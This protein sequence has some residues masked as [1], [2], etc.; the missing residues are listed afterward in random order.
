[1]AWKKGQ[2]GNPKGRPARLVEKSYLEV[3]LASVSLADWKK[4]V[5][6]AKKEAQAGGADGARAREWLAK[7]LMPEHTIVERWLPGNEC[8]NRIEGELAFTDCERG[9]QPKNGIQ[10]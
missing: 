9:Q 7:Y 2:S 5:S 1:M 3:T 8:P 10:A 6:R 4:V